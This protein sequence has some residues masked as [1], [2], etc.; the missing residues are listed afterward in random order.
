MQ[1][2]IF[3]EFASSYNKNFDKP[4]KEGMYL[5]RIKAI[6]DRPTANNILDSDKLKSFLLKSR[7]EQECPLLP[8]LYNTVLKVLATAIRLKKRRK[9]KKMHLNWKS[10][11]VTIYR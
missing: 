11:T 8:L 5:N 7:T 10:K 3:T 1:K 2:S 9:R 4:V 6:Y